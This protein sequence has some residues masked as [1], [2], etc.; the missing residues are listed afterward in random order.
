MMVEEIRKGE[1]LYFEDMTALIKEVEERNK[2]ARTIKRKRDSVTISSM[3]KKS[4]T[5]QT[6]ITDVY[7]ALL[8]ETTKE[9]HEQ[10]DQHMEA[11][12]Q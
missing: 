9:T 3:V 6:A 12:Q 8:E 10:I 1:S 5:S 2:Q 7:A 4:T 11:K